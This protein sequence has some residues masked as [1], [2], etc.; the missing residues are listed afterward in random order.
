[1]DQV[2]EEQDL[3]NQISEAISRP[4]EDMFDN[5]SVPLTPPPL[6]DLITHIG[7]APGR[8]RRAGRGD[9]R[10][11][12]HVNSSSPRRSPPRSVRLQLPGGANWQCAGETTP[13]LSVP[14]RSHFYRVGNCHDIDINVS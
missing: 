11:A 5:V 8:T 2:E 13:C 7:G 1:M 10:A 4:A 3:M 14:S 9:G 12:E 6:S